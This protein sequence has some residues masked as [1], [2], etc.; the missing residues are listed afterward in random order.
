MKPQ[1]TG[2][3][4]LAA[5][6]SAVAIY[7]L[8]GARA[9][10]TGKVTVPVPSVSGPIPV[11]ADSHPLAASDST[12][13]PIDLS[14]HGYVEEEYFVRGAGSV[15]DW[16]PDG[17]IKVRAAGL[18]YVTRILVRRPASRDRFSGTILVDVGNRGAGFDTFAV[19]GQL[20]EHLLASGHAYVAVTAFANNIGALRMF[21]IRRYSELGYPRPV[22]RCGP[23]NPPR[24]TWNRPAQFFPPSEDGI[25][26]D[27]ISQVGALLKAGT[28]DGPMGGYPVQ[29]VYAGMQSG[30]DLP[31]YVNAIARNVQLANGKPVYDG[32]IIKDSG[33]PGALNS[34]SGPL[35][36]GDAR[37]TIRNVGVPVVHVVAQNATTAA[38]RRPDSDTPGDQYRRYELPGA[39]HFDKWQ[40]LY[41]PS[42]KDLAAA[43]VP[44]LTAHWTFPHE[45]EPDAEV[46]A[47]PQPYIFSGA[48]ANLDLWVRKGTPPPKAG[49]IELNDG[50]ENANFVNDEYGNARGGVRTPWVDVPTASFHPIRTGGSTPFRCDDNGY[51]T[52]FNWQR[53]EAIYGNFG[54][55]EKKFMESVDRLAAERWVTPADADKIRAEFRLQYRRGTGTAAGAP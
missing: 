49:F 20:H 17:S 35:P 45:C 52:P 30:G 46:N 5:V 15:Y 33:G 3:I 12:Q 54:N 47:F 14:S 19:W 26:W 22:E 4:T 1:K 41:Y 55:F 51:W 50:P 40:F 27:V 44:P 6:L 18:P 13:T 21:D 31:T 11:T 48:F 38:N 10:S 7:S 25:R 37:R 39:S 42:I 43:G 34:C 53:L 28:S 36:A 23:N 9:Q 16:E 8:P 32:F 29:Y 24:E 2:W